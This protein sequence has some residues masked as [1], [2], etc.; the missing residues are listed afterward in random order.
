MHENIPGKYSNEFEIIF[1]IL[2][3]RNMPVSLWVSYAFECFIGVRPIQVPNNIKCIFS[4]S[5]PDCFRTISFESILS[6][7]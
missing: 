2:L 6:T 4:F 1:I 3:I 5:A 7:S